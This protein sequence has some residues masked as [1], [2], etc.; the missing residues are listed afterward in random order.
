M[1]CFK[2]KMCGGTLDVTP[3]DTVVTCE[4]CGTRQTLPRLDSERKANLYARANRHRADNDY[5]RA[6]EIYEQILAEDN[7]DAEAYWSLVLCRYGIEYVKDPAT[8]RRIPTV[9]RAQMTAVT[10]DPDYRAALE[11]ADVCQ[12]TVY[13]EEARAIDEIQRGILEISEKEAPFDV[14][15]CYKETDENG[16]RTR[17]SVLAQE[18]YFGLQSEGFRVF[19]SR[20]TLEDKLGS[21][22]EPYIFAALRSARVMVVVGTRPE[23]FNAVWVKNEWKRYLA[24]I[25]AGERKTLIPA[26]RDMDPYELPEEFSYLQAQD[27]ERLGFMQEMIRGI[28]KLL[29]DSTPRTERAYQGTKGHDPKALLARAFQYLSDGDFSSADSYFERVLDRDPEHPEAHLGRLMVEYRAKERDDLFRCEDDCLSSPNY[30]RALNFAERRDPKLFEFLQTMQEQ[31]CV[32]EFD[33][34]FA[35][36]KSRLDRALTARDYENLAF[37]FENLKSEPWALSSSHYD[38]ADALVE[39]CRDKARELRGEDP[40]P[41]NEKKSSFTGDIRS[42][43]ENVADSAINTAGQFASEAYHTVRREFENYEERNRRREEEKQRKREERA[44]K[45]KH[46]LIAL[47]FTWIFYVLT[48]LFVLITLDGDPSYDAIA[49]FGIL[50]TATLLIYLSPKGARNLFGKPKGIPKWV[51]LTVAIALAF[52]IIILV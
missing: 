35:A 33:K 3:T 37:D 24:L 28:K 45:R 41:R 47:I 9:N 29:A 10:A 44:K 23:Y 16:K 43:I 11:H 25:K 2:C 48:F 36:L 18:L 1:A 34:K 46:S 20:I 50:G 15:I 7:T 6:A 38:E 40:L 21:A 12:R 51:A 30:E 49:V 19:F 17:D 26:Y 4:Y 42:T 31:C 13:E 5:D 8:G 39:L 14:F 32:G 22:Y 52:S 27:M